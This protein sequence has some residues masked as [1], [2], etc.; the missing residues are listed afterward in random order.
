[1]DKEEGKARSIQDAS[2]ELSIPENTLRKYLSY[3]SIKIDKVG[4]KTL[5]PEESIQCLSEILQLKSNGWSLKQIKELREKQDNKE[6]TASISKEADT[7]DG[8]DL[9]L[10]INT[11]LEEENKDLES[12][13]V[14][15]SFEKTSSNENE[16]TTRINVLKD[17]FEDEKAK[18]QSETSLDN[19]EN[20]DGVLEKPVEVNEVKDSNSLKEEIKEAASNISNGI[21][22]PLTKDL[23]NKEIA[24]QA[25]RA[26]RLYRYLSSRHAPRD[27]AEVKADLDRRVIFLNGLRYLRDNWLDRKTGVHQSEPELAKV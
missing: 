25:K 17:E 5:L 4:R 1:M 20:N 13:S 3:F 22:A 16:N 9:V 2:K 18:I 15:E 27:T 11:P 7:I 26:S 14:S 12:T 23:V 19:S 8:N 24:S 10:N 21:K 6:G